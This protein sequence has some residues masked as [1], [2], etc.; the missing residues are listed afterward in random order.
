MSGKRAGSEKIIENAKRSIRFFRP[1]LKK[2]IESFN[3]LRIKRSAQALLF[4]L[5]K[6][7]LIPL[8]EY[9]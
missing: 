7:P 8:V 2:G 3:F 5:S 6:K 9:L 1:A 4:Y